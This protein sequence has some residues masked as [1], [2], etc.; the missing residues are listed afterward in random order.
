M[1]K[2]KKSFFKKN[3]NNKSKLLKI[4]LLL[5]AFGLLI[6]TILL[7]TPIGNIEKIYISK[8]TNIK[9]SQKFKNILLTLK[10]KKLLLIKAE[11]ID[12]FIYENIPN[13]KDVNIEKKLP[14][15][16]Y[17]NFN[18]Y[19]NKFIVNDQYIIDETGTIINKP[20]SDTKLKNLYIQTETQLKVLDKILSKEQINKIDETINIFEEK[21]N[22]EVKSVEY[23][24]KA[25]EIHLKTP[26]GTN[27]WIDANKDIR[28][29]IMKLKNAIPKIDPKNQFYYHIDLR[30]EAKN[31]QKIFYKPL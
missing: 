11:Q 5:S 25:R 18:S 1:F 20:E 24:T 23:L 13:L 16:I 10:G 17:I 8:N 14:N 15:K 22:L 12:K 21:I 29:Q 31:A 26:N 2:K 6:F 4:I 30:I 7:F 28:S 3:K 27:I 19:K 9:D